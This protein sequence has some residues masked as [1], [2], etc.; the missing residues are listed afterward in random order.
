MNGRAVRL[1]TLLAGAGVAPAGGIGVDPEIRGAT[2]DSREVQPG[3][4]FF[5][6]RGFRCDGEAFVS[7]AVERGASAVVAASPRPAWLDERIAWVRAEDTRRTAGLVAREYYARPDE[8][9]TLVGIT[10]TNGKTSVAW[11]VDAIARAAGRKTGRIGTVGVAFGGVEHEMSRTTPEAPQLYR[12]LAE[13]RESSV[14]V[15][16]M[17]V[18]SH[19]L[20]LSRVAGARFATAAFLNL[21]RDHLDFHGS[22]A[23]Y[24]EAKAG[25]FR[26]LG[27]GQCAV[28]PADDARG[29]TLRDLTRAAVITFGRSGGATVRLVEEHCGLDGSSAVLETSTGRLPIRTFLPGRF[30]LDNVAAA[31]ACAMSVGLPPASI[32]A[33]VLSVERI[34]G[35]MERV[36][37]G[38]P[39]AVIV[40]YAHT[41]EAL[42]NLLCSLRGQAGGKLRLVFGCGG[43][44]D[45]G[46]R[47]EMGRTAATL[48]D[49]VYVTSD[50]PRGEDPQSII[51]EV[52]RGIAA[53]DG[54]PARSTLIPDRRE[55]IRCAIG[56]AG[57]G[58]A[59]VL[60]GKGHETTQTIG[61]RVEPLDDREQAARALASLGWSEDP[62]AGA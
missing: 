21:G 27:P 62:R 42:R 39:F 14:D 31:A 61:D 56:E 13:M 4:I 55:A 25:L 51:D 46:K 60:A 53:V 23:D 35:R 38:Q 30:N 3:D 26:D 5:A 47:F 2:L 44:R 11:L 17:E 33:G 28:L 37:R 32:P 52:Q 16:A 59:V 6:I 7:H 29:E 54:G 22:E 24:F 12:M 58:D 50:N 18:S 57:S 36:D 20:A 49:R 15:V 8:A 34:P 43:N 9:L 48:A 45:R 1:S 41:A 19:A 10:G 40:D